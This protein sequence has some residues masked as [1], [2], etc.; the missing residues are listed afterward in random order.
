MVMGSSPNEASAPSAGASGTPKWDAAAH[1]VRRGLLIVTAVAAVTGFLAG[2]ARLGVV[3]AWGPTYFQDHGPL[4]VV[5]VFGTVIG[6]ERAVAL[7]AP[8]GLVAPA[9]GAATAVSILS[10]LVVA[11]ATALL[12][13]VALLVVNMA[14]VRR[15]AA[16]FTWI[17]LLGSA[18]LVTGVVLWALGRAVFE[19]VPTWMAFFVL[20]IGAERLELSRLAPRPPWASPVLMLLA[21]AAAG[22]AVARALGFA[23][24]SRGLG[25][26]MVFLSAWQLRFD[27]ARRTIRQHGL[28]RYAAAGVLLGAAWLLVSGL[29]LL[30]ADLPPAGALYDAALHA[31]LVGYVLS[32]VFAHAPIILPAVMRIDVAFTTLAYAPLALLHAGLLTRIVGDM[33]DWTVLRQAGGIANAVSLLL[34]VATMIAAARRAKIRR[35]QRSAGS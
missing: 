22:F 28:P 34:F 3:V 4:L 16:P 12:S 15:Q 17:M 5:G 7:G 23:P 21:A 10:G 27:I 20:T 9:F 6:L 18:V 24:G 32:M 30:G 14:I 31:V 29:L 11:Q 19:V 26:A 8:W 1:L 25:A 33:A 2:L 35:L 13:T